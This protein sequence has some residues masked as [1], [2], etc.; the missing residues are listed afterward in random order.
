MDRME[1]LLVNYVTLSRGCDMY[2]YI[3]DLYLFMAKT[4]LHIRW[5]KSKNQNATESKNK[6]H[7]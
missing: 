6:Y 5:F 1:I 4:I 3:I 2:I 7:Y